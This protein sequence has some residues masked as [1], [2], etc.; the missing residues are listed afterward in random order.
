MPD[1][2]N[3]FDGI[4]DLSAELFFIKLHLQKEKKV[5]KK[6]KKNFV[7]LA[8]FIHT[9]T[10]IHTLTSSNGKRSWKMRLILAPPESSAVSIWSPDPS[11]HLSKSTENCCT[12][13]QAEAQKT[14]AHCS[15]FHRAPVPSALTGAEPWSYETDHRA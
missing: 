7:S 1:S 12:I 5:M 4:A 9:H 2:V 6:L 14:V 3:I 15:V 13:L 10:H 8:V 11:I